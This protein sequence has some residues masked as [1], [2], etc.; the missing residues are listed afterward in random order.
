MFP[1]ESEKLI[2]IFNPSAIGLVIKLVIK[3][4][5]LLLVFNSKNEEICI[6]EMEFP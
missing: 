2:I 5:S 1:P 3:S 6:S 4:T